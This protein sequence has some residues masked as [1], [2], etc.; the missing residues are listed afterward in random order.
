M[1]WDGVHREQDVFEGPPWIIGEPQA[2]L[3]ALIS[4]GR[5]RTDTLDAGCGYAEL[6]LALAAE[7]YTAEVPRRPHPV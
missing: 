3:A 7:G 4:A 5:A 2:E 6:S 1:D